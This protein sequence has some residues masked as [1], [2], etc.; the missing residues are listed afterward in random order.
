MENLRD[1]NPEWNPK[2]FMSDYSEAEL[3]AIE[4][5]FPNAKT[6]LCDFHREQAWIRSCRDHTH[7]LTQ[8]EADSLLE[9]LRACAWAPPA[10]GPDPA[11][12]FKEAISRLKL[13]QVWN[14]HSAIRQWLSSKW[15][16]IPEVII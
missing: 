13:S 7:G 14:Y 5:V 2:Y 10:D 15:L 11:Q 9:L 3:S 6:Y 12:Y 8:T 4:A 1:W 16:P